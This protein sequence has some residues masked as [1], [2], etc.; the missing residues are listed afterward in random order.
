M[1]SGETNLSRILK[2]LSPELNLGEYIFY[3]TNDLS[4]F[5]QEDVIGLFKEKE[6]VTVIISKELADRKKIPYKFIASW[7]TLNVHSS[8]DAVGLTAEFSTALTKENISANV[9]AGYYH[10]HIFVAKEDAGKA[11]K[12]LIQLAKGLRK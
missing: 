8:L 2:T 6:G 9:I 7:I 3:S 5:D 11:M 1:S 12:S 4:Q 10:D